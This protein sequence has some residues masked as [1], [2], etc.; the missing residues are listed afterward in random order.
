MRTRRLRHAAQLATLAA[1][2]MAALVWPG[3]PPIEAAS[4]AALDAGWNHSCTVT[5]VGGVHCWGRGGAGQLG[6]GSNASINT[7]PVAVSGLAG[8]VVEISAHTQHVCAVDGAGSLH[9][10]GRNSFGQLGDGTQ[11]NS[12]TPVLATTADV[13]AVAAGQV[14]TCA[15]SFGGALQCWGWNQHGTLGDGTNTNSS[16]PVPVTGLT[17]GVVAVS[18]ATSHTC[19]L[20]TTGAVLCW[21]RNNYG[22]LGDGTNIDSNTPVAVTDLASGVAAISARDEGTC[23]VTTTGGVACW[24]RNQFGQLGIGTN[25]DSSTPNTVFTSGMVAVSGGRWH[26]CALAATGAVQCWGYNFYG[27][28]GDGTTTDSNTPVPVSGLAGA[29]GVAAGFRHTCAA[30]SGGGV[31]CWGDNVYGQ[32]GD[33]TSASSET[34]VDVTMI[35]PDSDG[36]LDIDEL[37]TTEGSEKFGGL[38]DPLREWDFYDVQGG[39]GGPP[40]GVID[41]PN[42]ILGVIQ[43][44]SPLGQPPYDVQFDRGVSSGPNPWN[45]TAPDGVIDLPNDILGVILQFNHSCQ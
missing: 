28:L 31:Q 9:C 18:A 22:Q 6:N 10:W 43:R 30:T 27:Q 12:N 34:A 44:F 17:S 11:T 5:T 24:G 41:L 25:S 39:G 33:G 3:P 45:M 19:A 38:R 21:G 16:S 8:G 15:V 2:T 1:V 32:L 36:C 37:R 35:D 20:T 14:H 4:V 26:T 29:V 7:T 13:A 23:A 42:D 40:D